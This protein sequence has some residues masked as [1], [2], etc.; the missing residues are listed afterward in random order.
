MATTS[1]QPAAVSTAAETVYV[2]RFCDGIIGPSAE[3]LGTVRDGGHIVANTAPGCWG[4]MITPAIKG[5]HEVTLPVNVEGA[6]VG[7]A[8]AIRI[9]AIDVT[10]VATASGNDRMIE[11][12]FNGDP[13]CAKVCAQCGAEDEATVVEGIGEDSVRCAECGAP[14]APFAFTN[15]YTMVFD[16]ARRLGMTVTGA[17]AE[18]FAQDAEHIAALPAR[19]VQHPILLFAPSDLVGVVARMRP[20][21]GQ[22]GTMPAIDLPDSHNAGD[23]G[24]F[25]VGA[26]HS[27]AVTAEQLSARTDGHL[28]IDAV[29]AG[30]ILVCPVKVPGG[31]VYLGDMHAM[32]G[33]GEIA[34]HTADVAG[35]VTLQVSVL[36][37]LG[38]DGPILFPVAEDLPFLARPLTAGERAAAE[39][40]ARRYG[41][42]AVEDSLPVSFVGT[43]PDL[44]TAVEN[45]LGRAAAVLGMEV[46]EV[47]N[48]ATISGAIEIGRAPGVVQV[49]FRAPVAALAARGLDAPARE[50]Y[51]EPV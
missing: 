9:R 24:A 46:P 21:M 15:G 28:D 45:G 7:D 14:A 32:Q 12:R 31:G 50:Q 27:R 18:A 13:Y 17:Q 41:G 4:P 39:A 3:V 25:L 47:M 26:P 44:N 5:G 34:G 19:S 42:G 10:S 51:G 22:L 33:D 2:D 20:F 6:E 8:I 36:K 23:F 1:P 40:L 48:R 35:T 37:G 16:E 11:G 29:R 38:L 30:A 43:G 49:T